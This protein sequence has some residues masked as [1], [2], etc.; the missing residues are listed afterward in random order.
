MAI[1]PNLPGLVVGI[2]VNGQDLPEFN[3]D[4]DKAKDGVC[5]KYIEAASGQAFGI[6]FRFDLSGFN[7]K[8]GVVNFN[9]CADGQPL[10]KDWFHRSDI[11]TDERYVDKEAYYSNEIGTFTAPMLFGAL[12]IR[13]SL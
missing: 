5:V 13:K 10:F 2:D 7:I 11:Q 9:V 4:E 12:N 3:D 6:S 8:D 1:H